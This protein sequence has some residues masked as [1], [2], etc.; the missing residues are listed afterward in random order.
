MSPCLPPYLR[1][2]TRALWTDAINLVASAP[3]FASIINMV[4]EKRIEAGKG[5]VGFVNPALYANPQVL[6]DVTNGKNPGCGTDG[7]SAV[8]GWDPLTGLGTPNYPQIEALFMTL[9]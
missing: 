6:N 7:F 1:L 3:V 8:E 2:S 5:P 4:N 9:P